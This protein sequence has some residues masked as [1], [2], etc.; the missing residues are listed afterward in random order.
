G[1]DAQDVEGLHQQVQHQHQ[2]QVEQEAALHS[3]GED[4][5]GRAVRRPCAVRR[6][7]RGAVASPW[8]EWSAAL[9]V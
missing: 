7:A 2:G 6:S 1:I 9:T 3:G 8:M 5:K 4:E